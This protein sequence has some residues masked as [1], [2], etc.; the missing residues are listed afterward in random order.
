MAIKSYSAFREPSPYEQESRRAEQQRRLAEMLQQQSMAEEDPYTFQGI[1]AMPSPAAALAKMLSAYGAKKA[2]KAAEEAESKAKGMEEQTASQI[3]G[4]LMGGAPLSSANTVPD[5]SGLAEVAV[6]SQYR[7]APEDAARLSMTPVGAAAT[8]G[9]PMLAA[10]LARSM[11]KPE[12]SEFGTTPQYDDQG[13]AFVVNKAGDVRYLEGVKAPKEAPKPVV[14]SKE[15]D[16]GNVVELHYSDGSVK[17]RPKGLAPSA[18]SAKVSEPT[19]GERKDAYNLQRIVNAAQTIKG[20]TSADP[21][22][23]SP[24]FMEAAVGMLPFTEGIKYR[25]QSPQRQVVDTAQTD[26]VDA[27]LTLATGAA[28]TAEQLQGQREALLPRY[29]E[30][31]ESIAAKKQRVRALAEAAKVRAGRAW[32]PQMQGAIESVFGPLGEDEQVIKLPSRR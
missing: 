25:A 9:N 24:G 19:E 11:E 20:A 21:K 17:V 6:E 14:L 4:R 12:K 30:S 5:A 26:L 8:R 22:A 1:R 18:A 29:G 3:A 27:F 15:V 23:V 7:V 31:K 16:L 32:T 13:R 28:Y 2:T 10:M